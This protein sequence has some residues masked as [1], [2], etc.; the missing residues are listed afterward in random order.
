[1]AMV[2]VPVLE[3]MLDVHQSTPIFIMYINQHR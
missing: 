1:V 3:F 2:H